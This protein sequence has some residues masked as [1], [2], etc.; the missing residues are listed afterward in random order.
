MQKDG[1]EIEE[2]EKILDLATNYYKDLFGKSAN[3][4]IKLNQDCWVSNEKV[5]QSE[6]ENLCRKFELEEIKQAIFN[7]EKNTAPGPDH[8]PV[9]FFQVCWDIIK[10][11]LLEMFEEFYENK[12]DISRLNYGVITLIP[13]LKEAN[14]IQQYRPICL[15]N[16]V[17]KIFSKTLMMRVESVLERIISKGQTAFLKGRSIMEGTMSL[18]EVIHDTKVKKKDGLVLKLDFEKAYDKISW[19]FLF[20]CLSQRGFP[21][22]WCIWIKEVVTSGTL[23]VKVNDMVG[24]Y[25]TSGKGVRQGDPLSPLLF[26]IAADALAKMIQMGQQNQLIK[27][28]IPEYIEGGLALLQYADDTI[29]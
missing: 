4:D 25:F 24:P 17:F 10:E 19:K 28:L 5:S 27:G 26:N 6:C 2:T 14:Q 16:V 20:E 3:V 1:I 21:E 23:S 12:L 8:M 18:H 22:K 7:M 11:D 13:K 29:L 9:E 15:L